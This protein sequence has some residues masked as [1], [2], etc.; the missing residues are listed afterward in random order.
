MLYKKV[1]VTGASG[2]IGNRLT[3][4]L[5]DQGYSVNCL[6]RN[7]AYLSSLIPKSCSV[8]KGDLLD[9]DSL[10]AAFEGC[11]VAYYLVHALGSG[12]SWE[13][14]EEL[15]VQHFVKACKWAG[16]KRIIYL[17]GLVSRS[18]EPLS[19]HFQTRLKTGSIIRSSGIPSISF[20][21][22]II[23]GTGSLSFDL[24]ATLVE[25]LPIMIIPK[26]VRVNGQPIY[27]NDV[28]SYLS[29]AAKVLIEESVIVEIGGRDV[30]SYLDIMK[31]YARL[32][33][34]RRFFISVPFLA[35]R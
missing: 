23:L 15:M 30:L 8:Y 27:V 1:L 4:K 32:K 26:W 19:S 11:E 35:L 25:R 28:L 3:H 29:N 21:A 22:S 14:D 34:R 20:R 18:D 16:V 13:K 2:Y 33:G 6:A 12:D 9:Y 17:G 24:V 31:E 7:P 5:I 10:G